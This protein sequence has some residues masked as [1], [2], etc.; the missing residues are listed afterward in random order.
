MGWDRVIRAV[1]AWGLVL[2]AAAP[3]AP[4]GSPAAPGGMAFLCA[5][6]EGDLVFFDAAAPIDWA[7]LARR[8]VRVIDAGHPTRAQ[9]EALRAIRNDFGHSEVGYDAP[10]DPRLAVRTYYLLHGTGVTPLRLL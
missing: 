8:H 9:L 10:V 6:H 7:A 5:T 1:L 2:A 4:A 3:G